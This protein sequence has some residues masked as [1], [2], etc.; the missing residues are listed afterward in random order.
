MPHKVAVY[1]NPPLTF[2][3]PLSRQYVI[4]L[5]LN[6][7]ILHTFPTFINPSL[8]HFILQKYQ[9]LCNSPNML[10]LPAFACCSIF[11]LPWCLVGKAYQTFK[12]K[13]SH[14]CE[15]LSW[16]S[17]TGFALFPPCPW[18][19]PHTIVRALT[20]QILRQDLYFYIL[21]YM[22]LS[23]IARHNLQTAE[24][25]NLK[26]CSSMNIYPCISVTPLSSYWINH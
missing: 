18:H 16:F 14:L 22:F 9:S 13:H 2:N 19:R 8:L 23:L 6:C 10:G 26:V 3:G 4:P 21:N 15:S 17:K 20:T 24:C 25:T 7:L 12:F 11:A 1:I 5:Y